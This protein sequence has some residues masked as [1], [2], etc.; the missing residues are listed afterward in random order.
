M[1]ENGVALTALVLEARRRGLSYGQLAALTSRLEQEKITR[2][3]E[4]KRPDR[5][6]RRKG[7]DL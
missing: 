4:R 7:E 6:R 2:A 3:Y 1:S 5:K